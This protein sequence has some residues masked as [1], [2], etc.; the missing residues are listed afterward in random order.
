M[1]AALDREAERTR[2]SGV[3]RVDRGGEIE[4]VQAYGLADRAHRIATTPTHQL[5][6]ASVTKG[7]TALTIL[8]VVADGGL[9]LSTRARSVLGSDLP[10]V[11]D[12]VTVEHLLS[13]RS[14]MS[15]YFDEPTVASSDEY[16]MPVPVHRLVTSEDYLPLLDAHPA[17]SAPGRASPTTA[18]GSSFSRSSPSAWRTCRSTTWSPSACGDPPPWSTPR[19]T[20]P[21][22]CPRRPRSATST[23]TECAPTCCTCRSA[24]AATVASNTGAGTGPMEHVLVADLPRRLPGRP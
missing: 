14:G 13:H 1:R 24:A 6:T 9:H 23:R 11:D 2:F 5:G 21:T 10:L 15:D 18:R 17:V 3:V 7:F 20:G 16:V 19:S 8:S 22:S 12:E 4:S